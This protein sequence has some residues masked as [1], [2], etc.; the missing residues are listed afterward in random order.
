MR[1]P[2]AG[3]GGGVGMGIIPYLSFLSVPGKN[4]K[5]M[6][7]GVEYEPSEEE[8]KCWKTF[9]NSL[10]TLLIRFYRLKNKQQNIYI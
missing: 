4:Q 7:K 8:G 10:R 1:T 2:V 5:L 6:L 9:M 3:D